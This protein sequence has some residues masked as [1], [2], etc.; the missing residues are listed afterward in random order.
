MHSHQTLFLLRLKGVPSETKLSAVS[1]VVMMQSK[2]QGTS[3]AVK[4][5]RQKSK[6]T[7]KA[8]LGLSTILIMV[9]ALDTVPMGVIPPPQSILHVHVH[10]TCIVACMTAEQVRIKAIY[11]PTCTLRVYYR[12]PGRV[13]S[14]GGG[15][16]GGDRGE[17]SP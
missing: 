10:T 17:V 6:F 16:G 7:I 8:I 5:Q 9:A 15:G 12:G 1:T 11:R 13:S 14:N 4:R 2:G 3:L